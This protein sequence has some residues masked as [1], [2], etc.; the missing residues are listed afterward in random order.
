[1]K[2]NLMCSLL[3]SMLCVNGF[4]QVDNS[5]NILGTWKFTNEAGIRSHYIISKNLWTFSVPAP[6][7]FGSYVFVKSDEI[8]IVITEK[9]REE[10]FV[11]LMEIDGTSMTIEISTHKNMRKAVRYVLI[12]EL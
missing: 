2:Q 12:K 10:R 9:S 8:H 4:A 1:M 3:F 6:T 7:Y 11:K 5:E